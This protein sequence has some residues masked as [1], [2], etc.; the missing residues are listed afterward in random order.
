MILETA[1]NDVVVFFHGAR[2]VYKH[3]LRNTPLWDGKSREQRRS[4]QN[5][6]WKVLVHVK[7]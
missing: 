6:E 5:R 1:S 3:L 4:W 7:G 2:W